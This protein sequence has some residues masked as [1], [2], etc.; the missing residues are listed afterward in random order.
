[1]RDYG[2]V[3]PEVPYTFLGDLRAE[4]EIGETLTKLSNS[5]RE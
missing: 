5:L 4:H 2:G 3:I 1:M